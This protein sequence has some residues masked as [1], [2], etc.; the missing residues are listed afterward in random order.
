M[1]SRFE[2]EID[3]I[4]KRHAEDLGPR[5][6]LRTAFAGL[7]RRTRDQLR[8]ST[9]SF[10]RVV[11]PRR[12]GAVGV[13]LLL[14]AY[15]TRETYLAILAIAVLMTAYLLSIIRGSAENEGQR[16]RGRPVEFRR[17]PDWLTRF[18]N[19]LGGRR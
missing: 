2:R 17:R 10:L 13:I 16:W 4:I 11:T 8:R 18:R 15:V 5:T 1:A 14:A 12:L 9:P 6:P 7:Q 3:E 19:W